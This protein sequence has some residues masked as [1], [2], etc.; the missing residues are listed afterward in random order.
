[1][2]TRLP[3]QLST[4]ARAF[5]VSVALI[6][7]ACAVNAATGRAVSL[8]ALAAACQ[9]GQGA[10]VT[11]LCG[12]TELQ[13][14]VYDDANRD[15]ILIGRADASPAPIYLDDLA[16]VLRNA[17]VVYAEVLD[18]TRYYSCPGCSIDPN[19]EILKKLQKISQQVSKGGSQGDID[20]SL[21]EWSRTGESRQSVRVMGIPRDTRFAK[22]MVEADYHLK[23][24]VN[25]SAVVDVPGFQS[26]ADMRADKARE[27]I[28]EGRSIKGLGQSLTRF[29]FDS[30]ETTYCAS[31]GAISLLSCQIRLLTEYEHLTEQGVG[32]TG[33]PDPLAEKFA[34]SFE[35]NYEQIAVQHP[36]Y[37][38]LQ[39]LFRHAAVAQIMKERSAQCKGLDYLLNSHK[40]ATTTVDRQV[41]GLTNVKRVSE[42][43]TTTEGLVTTTFTVQC[44][45]GVL[46]DVEPRKVDAP[47]ELPSLKK[48]VLK[49][50][51][52]AGAIW[53]DFELE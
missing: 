29:W 6:G 5:A 13:G 1:M 38:E 9:N 40:I 36:I 32:H 27:E 41:N 30:G 48:I 50:R 8:N 43:C 16:V 24:L 52:P 19:P 46:V 35:A 47:A 42:Q 49:A 25:G 44:C 10:S 53:W 4:A 33:L 7:L 21:A 20:A 15:I 3:R 2:T 14:Y 26:V 11:Q 31:D 17:W 39:G 28:R 34:R 51:K 45:G 23:R 12:I 18:G 22:T 37:R